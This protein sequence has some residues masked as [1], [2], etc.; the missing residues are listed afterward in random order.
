[1]EYFRVTIDVLAYD[2]RSAMRI[3]GKMLTDGQERL[4]KVKPIKHPGEK[5]SDEATD[6]REAE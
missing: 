4:A 3:A 6:T 5:A 1:M 2:P